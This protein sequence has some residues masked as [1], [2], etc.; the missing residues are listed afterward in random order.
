MNSR[1]L[2]LVVFAAL[3][4]GCYRT[5]IVSGRVASPAAL[6]FED[7]SR[8][9]I[10]GDIVEIDPP[11]RLDIN[12]RGGWSE[13][14]QWIS[15]GNWLLNA[16]VG[17]GVYEGNTAT[18]RCAAPSAATPAVAPTAAPWIPPPPVR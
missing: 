7:R 1:A 3:S 8:G 16:F 10:L 14:E 5:T 6:S 15:P 12:C 13:I 9:A 17:G 2:L 4:S 11:T 18:L